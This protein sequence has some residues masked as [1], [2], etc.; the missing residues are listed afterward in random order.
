MISISVPSLVIFL[1]KLQI[2][3]KYNIFN[4]EVEQV[5]KKVRQYPNKLV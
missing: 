4:N 5:K 1:P 2:L 3:P